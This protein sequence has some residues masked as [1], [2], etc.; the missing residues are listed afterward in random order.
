MR[1][2]KSKYYAILGALILLSIALS[3]NAQI[4][5]VSFAGTGA[6]TN[7]DSV[8]VRNLSQGISLTLLGTDTLYLGNVGLNN[9]Q[10]KDENLKVYPNPMEGEAKISF[11]AK[12]TG[13]VKITISDISGKQIIKTTNYLSKGIHYYEIACLKKGIYFI[14]V[15]GEYYNY[16]TKISSNNP[17]QC[18]V[19]IKYDGADNESENSKGLK[20]T[21][22][23]VN[24]PFNIGDSI[25]FTAFANNYY[26]NLITSPLGNLNISFNFTSSVPILITLP[27]T[28]ITSTKAK[29]GGYI[30]SNGGSSI[31]FSGVG[32]CYGFTQTP[33]F[34][35]YV[36]NPN[37]MY[38]DTFP[39]NLIYLIPD[40]TYY[41]RAF[42]T[43][44]VG[45]AF[46]NT[47]S[48]TTNSPQ[49]P[50]LSTTSIASITFSSA[51]IEANIIS[52]EG[53]PIT[54]RGI[55]YGLNSNPGLSD[56]IVYCGTSI[57]IYSANL[58]NLYP[59]TNYFVRSFATNSVGTAFG[60]QLIFTTNPA[61]LPTISTNNISSVSTTTAVSG[62][63]ISSN[64]GDSVTARGV[65]FGTSSNPTLLN[66][67]VNC[68]NGSGTFSANLTNLLPDT[69]YYLRAFATNSLGTA[70]G[71]QISFN[72][73]KLPVVYDYDSNG[74]DTVH[75]GAQIWLKQNL[76]TTH[77][78]NGVVIPN[79]TNTYSWV[80]LSTPAYCNY[81]N[82]TNIANVYGRLY[83]W[84]AVNTSKLCPVNWHVPNN[85]EFIVLINYLGGKYIA[86]GKL[87]E[88]GT[89]HWSVPNLGAT[90]ASGFTAL[91]GGENGGNYHSL[92]THGYW[93]CSNS[94]DL[95][96]ANFSYLYYN[97]T[98]ADQNIGIS[99]WAGLSV[100]CLK[101]GL[102]LVST[103]SVYGISATSAVCNGNVLSENGDSV[104][105]KGICWSTSPNPT[106]ADFKTIIGIGDGN[107][108]SILTGLNPNTTYYVR[109]YAT[110]S[111]G[112][113]Y[114][115]TISLYTQNGSLPLYDIDGNGY[116]TIH[117]GNQIWMKQN[118]KTTHYNNGVFI[119]NYV[120]NSS[121]ENISIGGRCYYANDS[122]TNVNLY[123]AIYN[124]YAVSTGNL[125][126][127]GWHVPTDNE[128]SILETY[129]GG[130]SIAGGKLKEIGT[131]HWSS[132]NT[133]ATNETNFTALPGGY[134][135]LSLYTGI[136]TNADW[137]SSTSC[138]NNSAWLRGTYFYSSQLSRSSFPI[139]Y[140][141]SVRCI[142]N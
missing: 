112:T 1:N 76:K 108:T 55:C 121:W 20:S 66:N 106:I 72:T 73:L 96:S 105:S 6:V 69:T 19:K 94:I 91:P 114:G 49:L 84:Y 124:W 68:G 10:H 75:I 110:N 119:Y 46:G 30:I 79:V 17:N 63:N 45:T 136:N 130:S 11:Y 135:D 43:N 95:G 62:G 118:L 37:I 2:R 44:T 140:G 7:V 64:G 101:N 32:V 40:T 109:A 22:A 93:W 41:I 87:K 8:K 117:I 29:S 18:E 71:N 35:D 104:F 34:N 38:N 16:S 51:V 92:G 80:Y 25:S 56:S 123:G 90:N 23:I 48:F 97:Y 137:W 33:T 9:I 59:N 74:Y 122:L 47:I 42:A 103:D 65:C 116:D 142:K 98:N 128:W 120:D 13:K 129:L 52:D 24:M 111:Y 5:Y 89:I 133:G 36:V 134:R 77:Y 126:P 99:K 4:Y 14:T 21:S 125:C 139:S 86:G 28:D 131:S 107:Y 12:Q 78:N 83:N 39:V 58:S 88:A 113:S 141:S 15:E 26:S 53:S 81:N 138:S 54:S 50:I 102:P 3:S 82:D 127:I 100:R 115:D 67:V 70:Y 27:V 57:G 132:P 31:Y 60:N 85:N 61:T